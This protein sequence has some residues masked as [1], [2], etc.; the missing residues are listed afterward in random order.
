MSQGEQHQTPGPEP[1]FTRNFLLGISVNMFTATVWFILI[2]TMAVYAA[3]EF[4]SGETAAGFAASAFVIG[5]LC[6]RMVAGKYANV[7]GRKRTL[8]VCMIIYAGAS[9][10]YFWVDSYESLIALRVLHGASI[11][12]G[13]SA[14]NAGVFDLI[15]S[16]R[17]GEGAGY[18]LVANS[19]P[20]AIGPLAAIQ[21]SQRFGFDAVFLAASG[22]AGIALLAA[23]IIRLPE[24]RPKGRIRHHL[25]LRP[26]EIIEPQAAP[27][28]LV[29]LI[30]GVAFSGIIT[31][32]NGYA[33]SM[34]MVDTASVF[35]V[36][37]A[38]M[39]LLSRLTVGRLQD[40]YGD[41]AVVY[42]VL[43]AFCA[44]LALI[45]WAPNAPVVL[46]AGLLL[47]FG[48][49]SLL[50]SVQAIIAAKLS[51]H[52]TSIGISTSFIL[53]DVGFAVAPF[54]LGPLVENFGYRPM[55]AIS[56]GIA[57]CG[58]VVYYWVHG[59]FDV[60]QG[61]PRGPG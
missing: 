23:V 41:N 16:T 32:L 5:A 57:L 52:R 56:A 60:R 49:G 4:G 26:G 48:F 51:P 54:L 59:R 7:L 45:A 42:P 6:A 29:M 17:R 8:V 34:G 19:L 14:L 27:I 35:F 43:V 2:T 24:N 33:Q 9:T 55:Y 36:V 44:A 37:Y 22:V 53:M 25:S 21:L 58:V 47:G 20:H 39:V 18:Y 10:G 3:V 12:F 13:Q 30:S 38:S 46:A 28:A 15:P 61:R 40:R 11:G 50:P 31:F 1:L